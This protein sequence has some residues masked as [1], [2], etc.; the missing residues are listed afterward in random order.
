MNCV[1]LQKSFALKISLVSAGEKR[2][3][4]VTGPCKRVHPN[5]LYMTRFQGSKRHRELES[6][7]PLWKIDLEISDG[8]VSWWTESESQPLYKQEIC[9]LDKGVEGRNSVLNLKAGLDVIFWF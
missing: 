1:S 7:A 8:C 2:Q 6:R 4:G 3:T 9:Q 5:L